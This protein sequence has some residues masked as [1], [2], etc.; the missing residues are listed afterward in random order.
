LENEE[1]RERQADRDYWLPL[2]RELEQMRRG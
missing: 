2:K 1:R